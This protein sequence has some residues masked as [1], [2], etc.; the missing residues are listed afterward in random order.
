M[1]EPQQPEYVWAFPPE[2]PRGGRGWLIGVLVAVAVVIA[3]GVVLLVLRPWAAAEPAPSPSSSVTPNPS[4]S[5]SATPSS[6]PTG[7]PSPTPTATV[8][9]SPPAT[10]TPPAPGD[11]TLP[12]F[13]NKMQPL[14][15]DAGT[16]LSYARDSAAQEGVQLVAQLQGDA[17]RMSDAV[18]PSSIA[19]EWSD[20][21]SAY[22]AALDRLHTAFDS[23]ASTSGPLSAAQSA[24]DELQDLVDG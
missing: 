11:P 3:I 24:L 6:T 8:V 1:S 20:R 18:A 21:V 2:K 10:A 13:R 16:G 19:Q 12:V 23:G 22:G 9:P 14:L 17:G 4:P 5:G 15:D 7:A